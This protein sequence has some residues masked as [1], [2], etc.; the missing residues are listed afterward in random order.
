MIDYNALAQKFGGTTTPAPTVNKNPTATKS[1]VD[2]SAL[3][4]QFGGTTTPAPVTKN[5]KPADNGG[6]DLVK[7]AK[8]AVKNTWDIYK[9]APQDFIKEAG[10]T[11]ET[12]SKNP[13]IHVAE[14]AGGATM[15]AI[16]T[17]FAPFSGIAKSITDN[18]SQA[19]EKNPTIINHPITQKIA[20]FVQNSQD[21]LSKLTQSHP[22]AARN[23]ANAFGIAI[24]ALAGGKNG[25]DK[26]II[27]GEFNNVKPLTNAIKSNVEN[28]SKGLAEDLQGAKNLASNIKENIGKKV[29]QNAKTE[30]T[31]PVTK[32][33]IFYS[34]AREVFNNAKLT[35]ND[36]GDVLIKNKLNLA[37]NVEN[38][39]YFTSE[40]ADKIRSDAGKMS[41]EILRP[42]LEE[43]N[44]S[45]PKTPVKEVIGTAKENIKNSK[46][47]TQ[48]TKD[49]LMAKLDK[50]GKSLENQYPNG[51]SLTD[52]HD[53]K[54][55]RSANAKFSPVG[56][57]STNLEAN[58][59][60][61]ISNA[62]KTTLET[63]APEGIPVKEFNAE[64]QKQFQ[65]ADYLDALNNKKVPVSVGA[66]VRKT[67]GK[68]VGAS[69]GETLGGGILG[70]VGGYHVG[71]MLESMLESVPN[72]I[73]TFFLR[74]LEITNPEAF[75]KISKYLGEQGAEKATRLA[76]PVSDT[77]PMG[78][79]PE[80]SIN[81]AQS[82]PLP[83]EALNT[84]K[85]R[86]PTSKN[87]H[88]MPEFMPSES[89][90]N[91]KGFKGKTNYIFEPTGKPVEEANFREIKKTIKK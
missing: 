14:N 41:K 8:D 18:V 72:P 6:I 27:P 5:D 29:I 1:S 33:N 24:T 87:T 52:L 7:T 20:D 70:G 31:E 79:I 34:K 26:P 65:A 90:L 57:I 61:A 76:L 9:N 11:D 56:D 51:L 47:I 55:T 66:K 74:N 16:N 37:D 49:E 83:A 39:K 82:V 80:K 62:L 23:V 67:V 35:G 60:Y 68:V 17:I 10:R 64:L 89:K 21:E 36:I 25:L 81:Y 88:Y 54:I 19:I 15:S 75:A 45:T 50:T 43:A 30:W 69:V 22:E 59:N 63:K 44:F 42:S 13:V 3:A 28:V 12:T 86:L 85:F 46:F 71:G 4:K 38:G 73:K 53:E 84:G 2:Y 91:G 77:I 58:K 78:Q 40:T 32:P 48:E